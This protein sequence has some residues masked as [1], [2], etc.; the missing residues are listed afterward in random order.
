GRPSIGPLMVMGLR[1]G[2]W[3][4]GPWQLLKS[5]SYDSL[6]AS[7]SPSAAGHT[8]LTSLPAPAGVRGTGVWRFRG[9]IGVVNF[10][11][12]KSALGGVPGGMS[13][14]N[15]LRAN[16]LRPFLRAR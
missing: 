3:L 14:A 8:A 12:P 5:S 7:G 9:G 6:L 4:T 1:N 13:D 2:F 16:G 11:T 15:A 10:C